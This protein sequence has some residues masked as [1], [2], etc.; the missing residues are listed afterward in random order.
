MSIHSTAATR[1]FPMSSASARFLAKLQQQLRQLGDVQSQCAGL[2]M[3]HQV[4]RRSP[5]RLISEI[6]EGERLS[7][8]ILHDETGLAFFDR[9]G[10]RE[11]AGCHQNQNIATT[12]KKRR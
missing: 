12:T 6:D 11:A 3:R 4:L 2:I 9:P 5:A 8:T 1:R 7:V 10:R